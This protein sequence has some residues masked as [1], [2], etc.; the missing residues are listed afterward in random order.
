M[1]T[2][3]VVCTTVPSRPR[4]RFSP[5][6]LVAAGA[7]TA[8]AGAVHLAVVP[9]HLAEYPLFG[10]FFL[11]VGL[12]QAGAAVAV[13]LRPT[14]RRLTLLAAA[15]AMLALLWLVSRTIGLPIGP[16]PWTPEQIGVADIAC[17]ALEVVSV[18]VLAGLAA[19][20]ARPRSRR[21]VRTPV[22]A[23]AVVLATAWVTV[24]GVGTG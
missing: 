15:E 2:R 6:G 17:V 4:P 11:V 19:R 13:T 24:I 23:G 14:R 16:D 10:I 1:S 20:G 22:G 5:V 7:L 12:A 9:E 18:A 8:G 21:R 3:T